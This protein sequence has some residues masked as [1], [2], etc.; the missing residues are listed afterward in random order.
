MTGKLGRAWV[1]AW[2]GAL[3]GLVMLDLGVG[4]GLDGDGEEVGGVVS[5]EMENYHPMHHPCTNPC[6][7]QLARHQ[8]PDLT[9]PN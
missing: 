8:I 3:L 9:P 5:C 6:T 1:G 2:H 4:S 7:A